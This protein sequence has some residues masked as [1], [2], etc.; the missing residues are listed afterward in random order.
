[1]RKQLNNSWF[2]GYWQLVASIWQRVALKSDVDVKG[3][4]QRLIIP[5]ELC[6]TFTKVVSLKN[7]KNM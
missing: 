5:N 7:I 2:I 3:L 4:P 1:M 6:I